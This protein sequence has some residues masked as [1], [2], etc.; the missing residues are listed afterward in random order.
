[1]WIAISLVTPPVIIPSLTIMVVEAPTVSGMLRPVLAGRP[2]TII[3]SI[4]V[5]EDPVFLTIS[6]TLPPP[7]LSQYAAV[8]SI[9]SNLVNTPTSPEAQNATAMAI[10]MATATS[11]TVAITGFIPALAF[12]NIFVMT[13]VFAPLYFFLL[14][15]VCSKFFGRRFKAVVTVLL[16]LAMKCL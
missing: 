5:S 9:F 12:L 4:T 7:V 10:T 11:M 3:I 14:W 6:T 8:I 15:F 2:F 1:V 13:S 16:F